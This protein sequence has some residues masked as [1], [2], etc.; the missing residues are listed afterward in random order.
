MDI[1]PNL[2]RSASLGAAPPRYENTSE[3]RSVSSCPGVQPREYGLHEGLGPGDHENRD[4]RD[5]N[6]DL[7]KMDIYYLYTRRI[8]NVEHP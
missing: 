4:E 5:W 2:L 8:I 3:I 6:A 1:S 7:T